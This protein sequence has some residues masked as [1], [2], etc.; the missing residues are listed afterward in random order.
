MG[1]RYITYT[2]CPKCG[3]KGT[4]EIY[5]APSCLQY[6]ETC[7]KCDY[8]GGKTYYE[9]SPNTIE[10]LTK[11]QAKERGLIY[12]DGLTNALMDNKPNHGK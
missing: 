4:L 12:V 1:D 6:V 7:D 5:D 10:L 2:D 11:K 8:L 3:G 9:T